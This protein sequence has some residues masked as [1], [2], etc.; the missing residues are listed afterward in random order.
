MLALAVLLGPFGSAPLPHLVLGH[1]RLRACRHALLV[2]G[3]GGGL[4]GDPALVGQ[5]GGDVV[6]CQV[7]ADEDVRP[8]ALG[9]VYGLQRGRALKGLPTETGRARWQEGVIAGFR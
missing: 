4:L 5:A 9:R 7:L 1:D 2:V 6:A 3:G 8:P